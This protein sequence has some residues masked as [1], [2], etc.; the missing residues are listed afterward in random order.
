MRFQLFLLLLLCA[1][2][3]VTAHAQELKSSRAYI[4]RAMDHFRAGRIKES[5]ADFESAVRLNPQVKP[6]L[7]QLGISYY[8]A[9][10]FKKGRELFELHRTVNPQD[11]E[12]AIWHF[13]CVSKLD[14]IDAARKLFIPITDDSRVPMKELHELFAGKIKEADVLRAA[15]PDPNSSDAARKSALF[16][17][18]LYVGLYEEALNHPEQS[19]AH[20][21]LAAQQ[22]AQSN[23][24]SDVARVHLRLRTNKE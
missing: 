18:H 3:P 2:G 19:L 12:N 15:A 7:W 6:Q 20:I 21:K 17:A 5:I 16:Y 23:Y 11:V 24:M 14:G 4:Q 13:L 8:Y 10:E 22:F 9:G 1:F